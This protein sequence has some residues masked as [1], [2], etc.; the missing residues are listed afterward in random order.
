MLSIARRCSVPLLPPWG[1]RPKV[2]GYHWSWGQAVGSAGP[3]SPQHRQHQSLCQTQNC[4]QTP[5]MQNN[6]WWQQLLCLR[7]KLKIVQDSWN[8]KRNVIIIMK[9][10]TC[11][12]TKQFTINYHFIKG[13]IRN[14]RK[15]WIFTSLNV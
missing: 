4:S 6:V 13:F 2:L 11:V 9:I 1:I 12:W 3:S 7:A 14:K 5:A 15:K 8:L 10:T